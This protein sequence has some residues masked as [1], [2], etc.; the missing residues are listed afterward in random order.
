MHDDIIQLAHGGGGRLTGDFIDEEILAR[1]GEGPLKAL[2]DAALLPELHAPLIFSTDSYVVNPFI[3]PGGTIGDLAIHG[4]VN[5]IAV[6]G[7]KPLW[8]SLA[9]ILEEG[10]PRD[11]LSIVLD[12]IKNAADLCEVVIATGDTKVV[13]RGLCDG[14]YINTSGIGTL[15]PGFELSLDSIQPGDQVLVSGPIGDHGMAVMS[16]REDFHIQNG[17]VSDTGTVHRLVAS[18][19]D[20]ASSVRFMRDPT[21]GG[22]ASVLNEM[23]K[24]QHF[25]IQLTEQDIP[26]SSGT[27]GVAEML[28]IDLLNVACEG[29]VIAVCS[30]EASNRILKN[31]QRLPEGQHATVMGTVTE[32][33]GLVTLETLTGARRL[34]DVPLGELLP[35]I[36]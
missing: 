35:R 24:G 6:A 21:R 15:R 12:A 18:M 27:K 23:V 8:I 2:P 14:I 16:A 33:Q 19:T 11:R 17:P 10:L 3:F 31:W 4:T 28:G 25:G 26:C 22:V 32:D 7:G 9:L 36:C 5:D 1:F 13:P 29:R 30:E 20:D 34:V